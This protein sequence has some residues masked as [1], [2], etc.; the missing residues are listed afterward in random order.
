MMW[1]L[2]ICLVGWNRE[3]GKW[4]F[5]IIWF[6][7]N[8]GDRNVVG[9]VSGPKILILIPKLGGKIGNKMLTIKKF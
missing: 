8:E 5:S 1:S 7:R 6:G 9:W 2:M 3:D 4:E